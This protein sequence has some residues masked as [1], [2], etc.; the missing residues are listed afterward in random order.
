MV[1][2]VTFAQRDGPLHMS[3]NIHKTRARPAKISLSGKPEKMLLLVVLVG[4]LLAIS[5]S[6]PLIV[7]PYQV[8]YGEGLLLD[9]AQRV[10]HSQPLYPDPFAFPVV[11]HV[12]GPVAY[13]A[14]A[15]AIPG[16]EPSFPAGRLLVAA[17]SIALALLLSC[18][19]RR[20]TG[21]WW[22]GLSFGLVLLTLPAFRFWIYLMRADVIGVLFS[23]LGVMLCS[24]DGKWWRWSV[25]FF[26]LAIF[27]KYTLMAAPLA[28][29]IHL[30][31]NREVR[32]AIGFAA[33]L[34]LACLLAFGILQLTTGH[35]FAFHMFSTHPDPYSPV[36]FFGLAMLVWAS[37]PTVTGLALWWIVQD[38]RGQQRGF[39]AIYFATSSI[40]ALSAGK[41]GSTTN[42]FLEWM[43]AS[44]LCAGLGY[45]LLLARRPAKAIPITV[46]LSASVLVGVLLQNHPSQQPARGLV[47]CGKAYQQVRESNSSRVLSQSLGPLLVAGK[48]ILVSDPFVYGQLVQHGLW[49]D[50]QVEHLVDQKYFG[51]IVMVNDAS[52]ARLPG[53]GIWPESLLA[54][55]Q[56]N[57]RVVNR[58][59]CR[60]AGVFLEP[61]SVESSQES[62]AP[63]K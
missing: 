53:A 63:S 36:Q 15:L 55:I 20:W 5:G 37:A 30:L 26:G 16:G 33:V 17:C 42:H 44:C 54:A 43:V 34:G 19:L 7:Q 40:T 24:V 32:Q 2:R 62:A 56:R 4:G 57:Y 8:D 29:V 45:S 11:L 22:I 27:C 41:L 21:S 48:P 58:Y 3:A 61:T 47:E 23:T 31:L 13:A 6:V 51:T 52:P 14:A 60:D 12:Y 25:P 46:L 50:R 38:S 1:P 59:D 39:A 28:V 18:I 35:W 49:P 10:R 9:G